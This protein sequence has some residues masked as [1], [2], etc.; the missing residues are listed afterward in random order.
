M[1]RSLAGRVVVV[2]NDENTLTLAERH[3]SSAGLDVSVFSTAETFLRSAILVPPVCLVIDQCLSGMPG[4]ELQARMANDKAISIVFVT[5]LCDIPTV[6]QA[7]KRGAID[8]LPKPLDPDTLLPAVTRGLDVSARADSHRQARDIFRARLL[9][10]TPREY[11]V[12]AGVL[13]G[14]LNKQIAWE[15]GTAEKTVKVHRGRAMEK[16]EVSSVAELARIAADTHTFFPASSHL[17]AVPTLIRGTAEAAAVQRL[18]S[19]PRSR[20]HEI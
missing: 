10:L 6:V 19:L 18:Q 11:Q 5:A 16:L 1:T 9:R 15:L 13:A 17:A 3:L 4:L 12:I 14:M 2:D 8:F 20:W 7:M